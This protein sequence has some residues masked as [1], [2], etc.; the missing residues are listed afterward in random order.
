MGM[1]K[2]LGI[3]LAA[4]LAVTAGAKESDDWVHYSSTKTGAKLY[5]HKSK[6]KKVAPGRYAIW[7]KGV[8]AKTEPLYVNGK[9]PHYAYTVSNQEVDCSDE[10]HNMLYIV[11]H[12]ADGT[13]V[14]SERPNKGHQPTAPDSVG[15]HM[16][17]AAC[18]LFN[19]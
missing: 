7:N 19:R 16:V 5:I 17:E 12:R 2:R 14:D 6:M 18:D 9:G 11:Y 13:V 1:L 8:L 4:M 15:A 10:T 3:S